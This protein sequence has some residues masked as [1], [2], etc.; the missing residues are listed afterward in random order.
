MIE[1][2]AKPLIIGVAPNGARRLK[3]DHPSIPISIDE[4][5][6]EARLCEEAGARLFHLHV[7]APDGAHILDAA[8]YR[9]AIAAIEAMTRGQLLVQITT[10]HCGRYDAVAQMQVVRDVRPAAASFAIREIFDG[11]A[12]PDQIARFF[13]WVYDSG[14]EPQ[15]ILYDREDVIRLNGLIKRRMLPFSAPS[16]LFV[17]GRYQQPGQTEPRE[18]L[19]MVDLWNGQGPWS[20]CGFGAAEMAVAAIAIAIGGHVRVGFENN[21]HRADGSLLAGNAEQVRNVATLAGLLGRSLQ[22]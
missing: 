7:R 19:A 20:A 16:V 2:S 13:D 3:R 11:S 15:F 6:E 12:E 8:L 21:L 9:Q 4:I 17:I 10:E 1:V 18:L 5:A 22:R 14:I